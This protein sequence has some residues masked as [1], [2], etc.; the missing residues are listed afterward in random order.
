MD[1]HSYACPYHACRP[2]DASNNASCFRASK[3]HG[4]QYA[5]SFFHVDHFSYASLGHFII[6]LLLLSVPFCMGT[7]V[8]SSAHLQRYKSVLRLHQQSF[9]GSSL[10]IQRGKPVSFSSISHMQWR[11]RTRLNRLHVRA[12]DEGSSPV[13]FPLGGIA[14][15]MAGLYFT[16]ISLGTPPSRYYVQVD[17]GSDLLWLNCANCNPC[18]RKTELGVPLALYDP[19]SSSTSSTI[20]CSDDFCNKFS[21]GCQ[22][23][24]AC[25]YRLLY[26]DGSRSEGFLVGDLLQFSTVQAANRLVDR[27]AKVSFGCG[28]RQ[29]GKLDSSDGA[30]DGI[31]GLG[32]SSISVISQ[33][34][35][36]NETSGVFAHCL[37]GEGEGGGMLVIGDVRAPPGAVYTPILQNQPHYNV[38][39]QSITINDVVIPVDSSATSE[40]GGTIVDSGTTLTYFSDAAYLPLLQ[41]IYDAVKVETDSFQSQGMSCISYSGSS[42][43][44]DAFPSID[45]NFDGG[46]TLKVRP[47]DYLIQIDGEQGD[48]IWCIGFQTSGSNN[49][50]NILGDIVLKDRLII[51]DLEQQLIGWVDYDCTSSVTVLEADGTET[52]VPIT[53]IP[54]GSG[55]SS[56]LK[57][58]LLG[59]FKLV[60]L[61]WVVPFIPFLC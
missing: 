10:I 17:T 57:S 49:S 6:L 53:S 43:V 24:E 5:A 31:L 20:M 42:N 9:N 36:N 39:L 8:A 41:T 22:A 29:T 56:T 12:S 52:S 19:S 28:T 59:G 61:L 4:R 44:E 51:Y 40:D 32:Q 14:P 34:R 48:N 55:A 1:R 30:L 27:G 46:S 26:G 23:E 18:P 50:I 33:L 3:A 38:N 15:M 13:I 45:L 2:K 21:E 7:T 25:A 58:Y 11:D 16:E 60:F 37:E 47:H 54:F 35:S